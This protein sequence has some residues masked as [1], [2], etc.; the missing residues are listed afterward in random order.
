MEI[1][2]RQIHEFSSNETRKKWLLDPL[3]QKFVSYIPDSTSKGEKEKPF[4]S[5]NYEILYDDKLVGDIKVYGD[6]KDFKHRTAQFLIIIGENRG[7]GVGS[8]VVNML[9]QQLKKMFI[10]IY[11]NV[12]RYNIA[13]IKMLQKNGFLIKNLK[14]NEVILYKTLV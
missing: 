4:F 12:N 13:S 1:K 8:T 5:Q 14:G 3:I 9:L 10:S 7:K 11:C 6:K 2:L